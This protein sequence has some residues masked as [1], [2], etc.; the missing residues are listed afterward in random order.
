MTPSSLTTH[1]CFCLSLRLPLRAALLDYS[2]PYAPGGGG[3]G[4]IGGHLLSLGSFALSPPAPSKVTG[5]QKTEEQTKIWRRVPGVPGGAS[6]RG[7][8]LP[9]K[10]PAASGDHQRTPAHTHRPGFAGHACARNQ[11]LKV[12]GTPCNPPTAP[13][14]TTIAH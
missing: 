3:F 5:T 14:H 8:Q 10:L 7:G 11:L 9:S 13:P 6:G 1:Y 12:P 2:L 4:G